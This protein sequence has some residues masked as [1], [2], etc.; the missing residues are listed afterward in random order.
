MPDAV[1]LL[2]VDEKAMARARKNAAWAPMFEEARKEPAIAWLPASRAKAEDQRD[3]A[4]LLA[5]GAPLG[6][7]AVAKAARDAVRP[8]GKYAPP[9][10]LVAG[11]ITLPFDEVEMLRSAIGVA[12]PFAGG[13]E[14]LKAAI[15][16]AREYLATPDL[17]PSP[18]QV[19]GLYGKL[20]DVFAKG[21]R[22]VASG[23]LPTQ[24]ERAALL[25]RSYQRR[26]LD[27]RSH[28]RALL[29]PA[30]GEALVVYLPEV[31]KAHLPMSRQLAARVMGLVHLAADESE[32]RP[33]ILQVVAAARTIPGV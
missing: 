9:M 17:V 8:D 28:V 21:R 29:A 7:E 2:W 11:E 33:T 26:S 15:E 32:A 14:A 13:D 10:V 5:R 19:E 3:A 24:V 20:R 18:P 23:Y 22:A 31:A 30:E 16:A 12:T 4:Y 1:E 27:G 25:D 6:A